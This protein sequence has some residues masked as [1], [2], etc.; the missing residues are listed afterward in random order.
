MRDQLSSDT[1]LVVGSLDRVILRLRSPETE[2][3]AVV[4]GALQRVMQSLLALGGL[5][6]ESMVRDVGWRFM[7]AG[8]RLE[9]AIAAAD[10]AARD[11]DAR[12]A[13]R[14][15]TASCSSRC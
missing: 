5:G 10:A 6:D 2:P 4:Q 8:R 1:W 14:R 13:A 3:Q 9:R 12:R 7:D 11:G 15:P